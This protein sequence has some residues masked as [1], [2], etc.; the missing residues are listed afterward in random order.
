MTRSTVTFLVSPENDWIAEHLARQDWGSLSSLYDFSTSNDAQA[1]S[2]RDIV[3][4]LGYTKLLPTDFLERNGQTLV[5]HE[6]DL[7]KG[8]G[9]SP[10]QW[11]ILEGKNEIPVRLFHATE[12][13]DSGAIYARGAIR[14][15]GYE[16]Y[17]EI[18]RKQ[19]QATFSLIREFL[20][21]YPDVKG[22]E[23]TGE[24]TVYRKRTPEDDE[25]DIDKTIR[26]QF[27]QFRI[28]N[29]DS[30]PATFTLDG[31]RYVLKIST[32][33]APQLKRQSNADSPG[34]KSPKS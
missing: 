24:A 6:S 4:A 20:E 17:P 12:A 9:F 15:T 19:A 13:A 14:L 25:L 28:A 8:K 26:E 3:F 31:H 23:Q 33:D 1:V 2:G 16:L 11:Q 22:E 30:W 34:T 10:V 29:N 7:P 21:A 27:N 18:R 32:D 5:V